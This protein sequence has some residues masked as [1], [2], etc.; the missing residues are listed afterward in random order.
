MRDKNVFDVIYCETDF[1]QSSQTQNEL[2]NIRK[3]ALSLEVFELYFWRSIKIFKEILLL[4]SR[5]KE[6]KVVRI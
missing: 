5:M 6:K 2:S 1:N 3:I 4:T